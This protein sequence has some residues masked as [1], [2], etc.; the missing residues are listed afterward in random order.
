MKIKALSL[1]LVCCMVMTVVSLPVSAETGDNTGGNVAG[2]TASGNVAGG[3]AGGSTTGGSAAG[4]NTELSGQIGSVEWSISGDA[5]TAGGGTLIISGSGEIP[6]FTMEDAAPWAQYRGNIYG[7][8]IKNGIT[9]I[10]DFA[11]YGYKYVNCVSIPETL[12][13]IGVGA[14][15]GISQLCEFEI[16]SENTS[17]FADKDALYSKDNKTLIVK[18]QGN[19]NFYCLPDSVTVIA[20]YAFYKNTFLDRIVLG[21]QLESIGESAF[22][23]CNED[24][25]FYYTGTEAEWTEKVEIGENNESLS[26]VV[27]DSKRLTGLTLSDSEI[28]LETGTSVVLDAAFVPE[29]AAITDVTWSVGDSAVAWVENGKVTG[30]GAGVTYV[31]ATSV[32]GGY[33]AR[34][35]VR[36]TGKG[37]LSESVAWAV[38]PDQKTLT[39]SGNGEVPSYSGTGCAPWEQYRQKIEKI[40]VESGI[41]GI[42]SYGFAETKCK[43]VVLPDGLLFIGDS[44]FCFSENLERIN[45]PSG[46]TS[47][48]QS[49]FSNCTKI[50]SVNLPDSVTYI[51]ANAFNNCTKM[52]S[53]RLPEGIES[54]E[55]GTFNYCRSL[56]AVKIPDSVKTIGTYAFWI[57][58]DIETIVLGSKV[59]TVGYDAFQGLSA[60]KTVYYKGTSDQW[61]TISFGFD[62]D[63]IKN[64]NRIYGYEPVTA[65]QLDT[66]E[67][68][69]NVRD[70]KTL[71]ASFAPEN[72][73]MPYVMWSSSDESVAVVD[74]EGNVTAKSK[75][76]ATITATAIGES[77][78][79][80]CTVTT[81]SVPVSGMVIEESTV[82]MVRPF[83]Q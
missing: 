4:G 72:A 34:C 24:L 78:S 16:D 35:T 53:L 5:A 7:I 22:Y 82:D 58:E 48:G 77:V 51:G 11:F 40:V 29:D 70:T 73:S 41:T 37:S 63:S 43:E 56:K 14:F 21:N 36:V 25:V 26:S 13:T 75:G 65:I 67:L 23:G 76:T 50:M 59:T 38:S 83:R 81:Q 42:G 10:G 74:A 57:C 52:V 6:D 71:S 3:A 68:E 39:I 49:A 46:L 66:A 8:C 18:M 45:F 32:D 62:N 17:F 2:G 31:R 69:M 80:S 9:G 54:I 60:L 64:A 33:S 79:A 12:E 55:N 15:A 19:S 20:P 44:A 28:E 1:M 61:D 27:Y 30:M 47:I